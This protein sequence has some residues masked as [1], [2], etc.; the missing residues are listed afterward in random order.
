MDGGIGEKGK[1]H[2]IGLKILLYLHFLALRSLSYTLFL[3][4]RKDARPQGTDN[5]NEIFVSEWLV[6]V[7]PS[8]TQEE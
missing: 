1:Q 6:R 8:N 3:L 5:M 4:E 7:S 2:I